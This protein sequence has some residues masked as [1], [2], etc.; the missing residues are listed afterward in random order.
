[1]AT[2]CSTCSLSAVKDTHGS[3]QCQC[4]HDEDAGSVGRTRAPGERVVL[5]RI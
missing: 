3:G 2:S 1:M 4:R 5:A